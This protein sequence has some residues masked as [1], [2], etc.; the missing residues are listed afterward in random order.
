MAKT[1]SIVSATTGL[2]VN[3]TIQRASDDYYWTGSAWQ[4]GSATVAMTEEATARGDYYEYYSTTEPTAYCFWFAIDSSDNLLDRGDYDPARGASATSSDIAPTTADVK[5]FLG[6]PTAD[7]TDDDFID[8]CASRAGSFIEEYCGRRFNSS[9]RTYVVDGSGHEKLYLPDWPITVIT[10]IYGPCPH[11]PRHFGGSVQASE[12]LDSDY[13]QIASSGHRNE[14]RD[15]ILSLGGGAGFTSLAYGVW[16]LGHENFQ[17]IATTG[18]STLPADLYNA[19]VM[20]SAHYY[21][22]G[23]HGRLGLNSKTVDGG[24]THY[25]IRHGIPAEVGLVIKRYR[26]YG[27]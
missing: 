14:A 17:V 22:L 5:L 3:L 16:D 9:S 27:F 24:A 21:N 20:L 4:A 7:T 13:Y 23:K 1:F 6:I 11:S 19:S 10:S 8:D 2:T 26:R 12:L 15:H 18:Y 25:E